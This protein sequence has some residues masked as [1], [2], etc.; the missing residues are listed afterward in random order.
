MTASMTD[1]RT[2]S[3]LRA[4][5]RAEAMLRQLGGEGDGLG[6]LIEAVDDRTLRDDLHQLRILRNQLAHEA[7]KTVSESVLSNAEGRVGRVLP[8]LE[9]LLRARGH[10]PVESDPLQEAQRAVMAEIATP[11][12]LEL[13]RAKLRRQAIEGGYLEEFE[14]EQEKNKILIAE[15][16]R[17]EGK[18]RENFARIFLALPYIF[19]V[20]GLATVF[21][22]LRA[23][24]V[25]IN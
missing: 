22:L 12:Q 7:H 25:T 23:C 21:L 18:R 8:Q 15:Q 19:L 4:T 11:E 6:E 3:I 14:A 20:I 5:S 13:V 1:Q 10:V 2:M 16:L 17:A 24:N 9:E